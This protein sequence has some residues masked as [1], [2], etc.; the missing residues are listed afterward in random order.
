MPDVP[1]ILGDRVGRIEPLES[2]VHAQGLR[3]RKEIVREPLQLEYR[4]LRQPGFRVVLDGLEELLLPPDGAVTGDA[5]DDLCPDRRQVV[6]F[7]A[8]DV[9]VPGQKVIGIIR[10][11]TLAVP[12]RSAGEEPLQ[13]AQLVGTRRVDRVCQVTVRPQRA[14]QVGPG[15]DRHDRADAD[16][17]P[18]GR[19]ELRLERRQPRLPA[20]VRCAEHRDGVRIQSRAHLRILD[21]LCDHAAQIAKLDVEVGEVHLPPRLAES[22]RR[23]PQHRVSAAE[24][25]FVP[26]RIAVLAAPVAVQVDHERM[27]RRVRRNAHSHVERRPVDVAGEKS[28]A[29][30]RRNR[31]GAG[32]PQRRSGAGEDARARRVRAE[33]ALRRKRSLC[34]QREGCESYEQAAEDGSPGAH[35]MP[36]RR[37]ASRQR[38]ATRPAS[39]GRFLRGRCW[40]PALRESLPRASRSLRTWCARPD[41]STR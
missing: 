18:S 35:G 20:A 30:H 39:L 37:Y 40:R 31:R 3:Q 19:G 8:Q 2:A 14:D 5:V 11:R 4:E 27:R 34:K 16:G 13:V 17:L 25:L 32:E 38:P 9:C 12:A 7:G 26:R 24:Q 21:G 15:N 33:D 1:E 36:C 29:L 28:R 23:V 10:V 6:R 22:T 41:R